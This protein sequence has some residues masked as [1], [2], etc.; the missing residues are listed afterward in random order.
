MTGEKVFNTGKVAIGRL[1]TPAARP[2]H[3]RDALRLQ[4]ALLGHKP[5]TDWD[6]III[7]VACIALLAAV[8]IATN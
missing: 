8:I 1:Y 3:D 7:A 4:S 6:G 5:K 2:H